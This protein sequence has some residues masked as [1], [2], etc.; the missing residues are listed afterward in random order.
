M[1]PR[2]DVEIKRLAERL[3]DELRGEVRTDVPL[4][5]LTTYRLGGPAALALTPVDAE[6]LARAA[7]LLVE[8]QLPWEVLGGGSNVLVA[9]RGFSGTVVLTSALDRL[10][11][12]QGETLI[13]GAGVDSHQ[14]A[15]AALDARLS[16]AEF[17]AWLP[18]SIG[19]ACLMN[20]RAYG[21]EIS[22]VMCAA[23]CVRRSDGGLEELALTPEQFS[24]K[25]SPF[26][27]RGLIV[28]EA[29]FALTPGDPAAS[30]EQIDAIEAARRA[31]HEMDHPSCGCVFK[32]DYSVGISSGKLIDACG[33]KGL[34]VGQAQV[35]AHHANFVVNLGGATAADVREVIERVHR[36]VSEQTGYDL[37]RE[38]QLLG[39]WV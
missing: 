14:V 29:T 17:L 20:A 19:G 15:L 39:D 25:R 26:G 16:G 2:T 8:H 23:R 21:G 28:A 7:A 34:R 22:G 24:Y 10:E 12:G 11:L 35:S 1:S 5:P 27:A 33:L 18:G 30:K 37:E 31:N 6:D 32:N 36:A 9:D 38:V 3:R 4:A 13:A